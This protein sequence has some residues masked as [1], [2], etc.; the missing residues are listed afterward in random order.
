MSPSNSARWDG[1]PCT[2]SSLIDTQRQRGKTRPATEYP[3]KAGIAFFFNVS[4]SAIA[5]NSSVVIPGA[6]VCFS[7]CS[8]SATITFARLIISISR[9]HLS[10]ITSLTPQRLAHAVVDLIYRPN[11]VHIRENAS[12]AIIV[13]QRRRLL[14]IG[15]KTSLNGLLTIIFSLIESP[16]T[17]FTD[18]ILIWRVERYVVKPS[19][20]FTGS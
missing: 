14:V 16:A 7:S 11:P 17:T 18:S 19:T 4:S 8:T 20:A 6:T 9:D 15:D 3:L 13:D 5:S 1:I 10:E 2:I 12:F